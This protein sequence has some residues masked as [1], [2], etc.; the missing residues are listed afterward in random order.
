MAEILW[1]NLCDVLIL[2]CASARSILPLRALEG[3]Q[4]LHGLPGRGCLLVLRSER[5]Q[6]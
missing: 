3:L 5:N 2:G 6:T 1:V 4:R